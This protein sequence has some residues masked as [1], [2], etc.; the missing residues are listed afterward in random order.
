MEST[1]E[2]R[3]FQTGA[4]RDGAKK[5]PMLQLISPYALFRLGEWLRF[6]CQD[7]QPEP[8]PSRNWEKGMPF[9]ETVGSLERHVQKFKTGSAV[10]DH[11]AA[12]MFGAM[13]I[14][15]YQHE[16]EA[17]RMDPSLD[18]MPKYE[19]REPCGGC[20]TEKDDPQKK[21]QKFLD[22]KLASDKQVVYI[23]GPMRGYENFNAANFDRVRF[24][25]E[26]CGYTVISPT[27]MDRIAGLDL[28]NF[29][30]KTLKRLTENGWMDSGMD[31]DEIVKRD[32]G[33]VL[34]LN[35]G[36]GDFL[37]ALVGA[38]NSTGATAEI[39]VA[40]FRQLSVLYEHNG[41]PDAR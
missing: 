21:V 31:I 37:F 8:Y 38:E 1:G 27:D 30:E 4:I 2:T 32:I 9:S 18:D 24:I 13:A 15:H 19:Q 33:V 12:I 34:N 22:K 3:T 16:I 41:Y 14:A 29:D 28:F 20:D 25:L 36:R 39:A 5:K 17:G 23:T 35:K 40:K 7:R 26:G 11:I 10:E 6:A